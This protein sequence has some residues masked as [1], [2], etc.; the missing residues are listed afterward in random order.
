MFLVLLVY[1][2]SAVSF[3]V[4][5]QGLQYAKPFFTIGFRFCFVG[6]LLLL[7]QFFKNKKQL[8][9][10]KKDVWTF[11]NVMLFNVYFVFIPLGWG[12]QYVSAFKTIFLFSFTPFFVAI[13]AYFLA[14]ER[15]SW[16]KGSGML[17][18]FIGM[19]PILMTQDD[20]REASME[21]CS[22]SLPELA[23]IVS[24]IASAYAWF[25]IKKL[26]DRGY[27]VPLVHGTTMLGGGV[28]AFLTSFYME[29]IRYLPVNDFANFLI[30]V[31]IIAFSSNI[32]FYGLY[33]YLLLRYSF[34]FLSFAQFTRP[35]F[36]SLLSWV[37]L[38]KIITW[39]YAVAICFFLVGMMLFYK[40]KNGVFAKTKEV[41]Q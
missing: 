24:V 7:F 23:V 14:G 36:G 16:Y 29:G 19:V 10:K 41:T 4:A 11:V 2:I 26:M 31:L 3:F 21:L 17:V 15:F 12:L 6:L 39:H 38:G 20:I 28:L 27:S 37:V 8:S 34:T 40:D 9:I 25:P 1:A 30:C 33:S 32:L 22:I 5:K 35:I 18:S 13:F